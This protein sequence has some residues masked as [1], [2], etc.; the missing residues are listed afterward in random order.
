LTLAVFVNQKNVLEVF[1]FLT[2]EKFGGFYES[3]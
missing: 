2:Q 1:M 3:L